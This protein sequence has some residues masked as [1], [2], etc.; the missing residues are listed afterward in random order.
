MVI[1]PFIPSKQNV[2]PLKRNNLVAYHQNHHF[3]ITTTTTTISINDRCRVTEAQNTIIFSQEETHTLVP[4]KCRRLHRLSHV[5][6]TSSR[7]SKHFHRN[8][9]SQ[10]HP[11][12][13]SSSYPSFSHT[14]S[15]HTL[16]TPSPWAPSHHQ[17]QETST[18]IALLLASISVLHRPTFRN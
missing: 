13:S 14:I 2:L 3:P 6:L 7:S 10:L 11:S 18:N 8:G 5:I 15:L 1:Y 4:L 9:S 16:P 17:R 12:S